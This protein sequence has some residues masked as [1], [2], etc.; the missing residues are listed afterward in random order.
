MCQLVHQGEEASGFGLISLVDKYQWSVWVDEC[1][2]PKFF[3]V[4]W[5][6]GV[7]ADHSVLHDENTGTLSALA[8]QLE[9]LSRF[10]QA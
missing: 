7:V 6:M 2:S 1:K 10:M 9:S 5:S 8:Q 4:K 3:G